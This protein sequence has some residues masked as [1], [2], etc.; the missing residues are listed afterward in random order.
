[1][2]LI[3]HSIAGISFSTESDFCLPHM[4]QPNFE[5]FLSEMTGADICCRF[6]ALDHASSP[7]GELTEN[8]RERLLATIGFPRK[9]LERKILDLPL[10]REKIE[11]CL[12][13]PD[14]AHIG[15][16]WG[17]VIIRNY[18]S[19]ELDYFYDPENASEFSNGMMAA[20]YRNLLAPFLPNFSAFMSHGGG[21]IRNGMAMVFLASDEGGK[22]SVVKLA[23]GC[24]V[25]SDDQVIL[26]K[27]DN[28][29]IV[30]HGTPFAPLSSGMVQAKLGG[31]FLLEK[32]DNFSLTPIPIRDAV[33]FIW[34]EHMHLWFLM[35]KALRVKAF[36]II[37]DA[38]AQAKS[39]RLGFSKDY[40]DWDV[41]DAATKK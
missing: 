22:S 27:Q 31:I 19:N 5:P 39:F 24:P 33:Q 32:S 7:L 3:K 17:R 11:G 25:L 29:E 2:F 8:Q 40:I 13:Y 23:V 1:M 15:L 20:R 4:A 36:N 16:R 18:H 28:N 14:L 41:V 30:A 26:R 10:V 35:P 12:A 9:W 21:I 6:Q 34:K 38:C 37:V